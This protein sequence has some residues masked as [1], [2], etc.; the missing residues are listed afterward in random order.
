MC[1]FCGNNSDDHGAFSWLPLFLVLL[2]VV[3]SS[4]FSSFKN[5]KKDLK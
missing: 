2:V 1:I 4:K 5:K 3:M